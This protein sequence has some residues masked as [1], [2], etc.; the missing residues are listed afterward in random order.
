MKRMTKQ[1]A[2]DYA[3]THLENINKRYKTNSQKTSQ[4]IKV[5]KAIHKGLL[6]ESKEEDAI[7]ANTYHNY[8][9]AVRNAIKAKGYKH[10]S[11]LS[12]MKR[13]GYLA[14]V[15]SSLPDYEN[16][17]KRLASMP[18][19]TIALGKDKLKKRL[20]KE[21]KGA[22]LDDAIEAL[23]SL[24]IDHPLVTYLVK[25]KARREQR[26]QAEESSL[27]RKSKHVKIYNFPAVISKAKSLLTDSSYSSVAWALAVLT[28]RRAIEILRWA[29]FEKVNDNTVKFSGQAKKREGTKAEPYDIPVLDKADN[30]I[31][32]LEYLRSM[33]EVKIYKSGRG[34]FKGREIAYSS[35]NKHD[36]NEAINQN[37]TGTLNAKAKNLMNDPSEVFK[38]TRGI[39]A[40]HCSDTVRT[41][42]EKWKGYNEDEFLKDILGHASTKEIK[43]YRQVE[44]KNE[45]GAE[46]LKVRE[47]EKEA[48]SDK[49]KKKAKRNTRAGVEIKQIGELIKSYDKKYIEVPEGDSVRKVRLS[50]VNKWHFNQL[51]TW[52][53][54]NS[55]MKITQ[56]AVSKNRGNTAKS[57]TG[58]VDVRVNRYT[59][60]AWSQIA[61]ELLE[62]YNARR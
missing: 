27:T 47:P 32:A 46:W 43:H 2:I 4:Y 39:Y 34:Q 16:E 19:S 31:K 33:P 35:L 48:K 5:A 59:F 52:A 12:R 20:H 56:S 11:L 17:L 62:N 45:K 61:G 49:P 55:K 37:T 54:E 9:T 60:R 22:A 42:S 7:S 41:T 6:S 38:N 36:L 57:G 8:L 44:L 58:S 18:A 50:S 10:P 15:A 29:E 51:S 21:L 14:K 13:K 23:D 3:L 53:Y 28:G 26:A 40:R 1:D 25:S 24:L 30:I